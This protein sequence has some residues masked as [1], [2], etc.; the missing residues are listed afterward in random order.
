MKKSLFLT[1][2]YLSILLFLHSCNLDRIK[3]CLEAKG[4]K[5]TRILDIDPVKGFELNTAA[6]IEL[7]DGDSQYIEITAAPNLLDKLEEDSKIEGDIWNINIKQCSNILRHEIK[8]LMTIPAIEVFKVNG[9]GEISA[10]GP[11]LN[12]DQDLRLICRGSGDFDLEFGA[13]NSIDLKVTGSADFNLAGEVH[14]FNIDIAGTAELQCFDLSSV[15]C[16]IE[17]SG[18]ANCE[19]SV[20]NSLIVDIDGSGNICYKGEPN[21]ESTVTGSGDVKSCE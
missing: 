9:H 19:V 20:S 14:D 12:T 15:D 6:D 8:I 2:S 10:D 3:P 16:D 4:D 1:L 13:I 11:L 7:I 21:I 5:E 18:S 17:I